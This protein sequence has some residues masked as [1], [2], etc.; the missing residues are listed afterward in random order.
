M[1][2]LVRGGTV[3]GIDQATSDLPRGDVLVEDGR[4]SEVSERIDAPGAEVLDATG[5]LVL[6]GFVDT[7][8][9]TWQAVFRG[10]G[11]DW[12]F[13]EYRSAMH[14]TVRPHCRPEDVYIG[15]LLG[16]VEALQSGITTLLDW[17]HCTDTPEHG[18]AALDALLDAPGRASSATA[19]ESARPI[20]PPPNSPGCAI[21]YPATTAW[22]RWRRG[23]AAPC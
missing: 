17:C 19:P 13:P 23:C 5:M 3:L 8:R 11:A 22:S 16:R 12:T 6:P 20:R 10:I 4:I 14:G 7:H 18:D 15:T 9:H 1:G 2:I 21:G